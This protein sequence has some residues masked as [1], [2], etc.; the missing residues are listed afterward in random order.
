M[1][2]GSCLGAVVI[3]DRHGR[4][5]ADEEGPD[6]VLRLPAFFLARALVDGDDG[7]AR[8][9]VDET[10]E[11]REVAV[12]SARQG[13]KGAAVV[14]GDVCGHGGDPRLGGLHGTG[15]AASLG[16][17]RLDRSPRGSASCRLNGGRWSLPGLPTK[18]PRRA[19]DGGS[20]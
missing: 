16:P 5:D 17:A 14:G 15:A 9:S 20:L 18:A 6:H 13:F 4:G 10:R 7:G 2:R 11:K 12:F 3:G 19:A 1:Q 8:A